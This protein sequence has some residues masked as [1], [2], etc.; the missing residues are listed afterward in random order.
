[1]YFVV[2]TGAFICI[3]AFMYG[4]FKPFPVWAGNGTFKCGAFTLIIMVSND[5]RQLPSTTDNYRQ[6][7][8]KLPTTK[9]N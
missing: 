5:Y 8:T 7:K 1:M 6:L 2:C 4:A 9:I 3:G